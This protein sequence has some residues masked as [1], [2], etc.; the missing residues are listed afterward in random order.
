MRPSDSEAGAEQNAD[1][2][3]DQV[4]RLR[5]NGLPLES[6]TTAQAR[7]ELRGEIRIAAAIQVSVYVCGVSYTPHPRR[8]THR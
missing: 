6:P 2:H 7:D 4:D 3:M 5:I 8:H 1:I